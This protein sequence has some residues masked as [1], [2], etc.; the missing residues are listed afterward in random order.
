MYSAG[1][2]QLFFCSEEG[3]E[4][5]TYSIWKNAQHKNRATHSTIS[6]SCN[7]CKRLVIVSVILQ[8]YKMLQIVREFLS[9]RVSNESMV[10]CFW[11]KVLTP[12]VVSFCP[13]RTLM[14]PVRMFHPLKHNLYWVIELC[15]YKT[16]QKKKNTVYSG[17][18]SKKA[19][20]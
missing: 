3:E 14:Q 17:V 16:C 19:G 8:V 7:T 1:Q 20:P 4:K 11:A 13:Y 5:G 2:R 18:K 6:S 15:L 9:S 12:T 10:L